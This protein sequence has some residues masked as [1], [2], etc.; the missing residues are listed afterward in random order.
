LVPIGIGQGGY[1]DEAMT[2]EITILSLEDQDRWN[3]EHR[4]G[5]LPSQSWNYAWSLH[6]SGIDPK[7]AIVR[8]R[9]ARMLLPFYERNWMG[10]TDIATIVG[11]SGAS[12]FPNSAAPLSL[13]RRFAASQGWIAGYIQISPLLDLERLRPEGEL[14]INNTSFLLELT[15]LD[16][17]ESASR[18]IRRKIHSAV[19]GGAVLVDD[20]TVLA[21]RLKQLYP[22]TMLR[23]GAPTHYHFSPE[24]LDRWAFDQES[25]ILG[26]NLENVIEG[27]YLFRFVGDYAE[28]HIVGT[29]DRG[30]ALVAW[31]IWEGVKRLRAC[32]VT[33]LNLGGGVRP[34]DGVFRFKERFNGLARPRGAFCQIYD[35]TKYD[36]LCERS[37]TCA[38]NG[39]FPAYRGGRDAL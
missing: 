39:W 21:E 31:L 27:V 34:G 32:G 14:T 8:S 28:S 6:A 16:I 11:G 3:A 13:W 17:F 2:D 35:S 26:A 24:T 30:R 5:G 22:Q 33:V 15:T 12:I 25:L 1:E 29:T 9:G 4:Q 19:E 23:L 7:L 36:Q 10:S 37:G 38:A 20:R 18:T